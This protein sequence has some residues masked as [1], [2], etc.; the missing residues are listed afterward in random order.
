MLVLW[1][2]PTTCVCLQ[3]SCL[4][5]H[6]F[7][8]KQISE[9]L[10][11]CCVVGGGRRTW[12]RTST[13]R[14]ETRQLS[15]SEM[16]KASRRASGMLLYHAVFM[17]RQQSDAERHY[18]LFVSSLRTAS[19]RVEW[20]TVWTSWVSERARGE[21]AKPDHCASTLRDILAPFIFVR[22]RQSDCFMHWAFRN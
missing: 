1:G 6:D 4:F 7:W 20:R 3:I 5:R 22:S 15:S 13:T 12:L 8:R 21:K 19:S 2:G 11:S 10:M 17:P 9:S 18:S 14:G 16:E